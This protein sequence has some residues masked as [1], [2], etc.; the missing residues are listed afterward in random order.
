MNATNTVFAIITTTVFVNL[1]LSLS[2]LA[3][4]LKRGRGDVQLLSNTMNL[5]SSV[6]DKIEELVKSNSD[7][8]GF[9][10]DSQSAF[11]LLND[12]QENEEDM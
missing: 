4:V 1:I 12:K 2:I 10:K 11:L 9:L 3:K 6:I 5:I 7:I 8:I